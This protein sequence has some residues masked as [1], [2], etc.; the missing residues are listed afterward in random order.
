MLDAII[1]SSF[2]VECVREYKF[3]DKRR[4]KFDYAI[5]THKVAIEV[6]GGVWIQGRHTRGSGFVKDMEKY[7]EATALGWRILRCEPKDIKSAYFLGLIE[8]TL[9]GRH[10]N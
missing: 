5:P 7:N 3:H 4:W 2:S 9:N 10:H 1:K 8:K 6:E